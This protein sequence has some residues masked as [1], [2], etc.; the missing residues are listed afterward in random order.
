MRSGLEGPLF[1]AK[2]DQAAKIGQWLR[3]TTQHGHSVHAAACETS[4][5]YALSRSVSLSLPPSLFLPQPFAADVVANGLS[6]SMDDAH[7]PQHTGRHLLKKIA[8]A[9]TPTS[10]PTLDCVANDFTHLSKCPVNGADIL[11]RGLQ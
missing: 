4:Q 9:V 3:P 11:K 5:N 2:N 6:P 7:K 10:A 8:A 1:V